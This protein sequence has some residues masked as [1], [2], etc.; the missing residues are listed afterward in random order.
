MK[1]L[2]L[3]VEG[4][5]VTL[6]AG[7]SPQ[8]IL[9]RVKRRDGS[10]GC[11]GSLGGRLETRLGSL[12]LVAARCSRA[13]VSANALDRDG[14][15]LRVETGAGAWLAVAH[16]AGFTVRLADAHGSVEEIE[17][18]A[19]REIRLSRIAAL[20]RWAMSRGLLRAPKG[21]ADY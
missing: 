17:V 2:T 20:R 21:I 19:E 8:E 5:A 12:R 4:C 14:R 6:Y 11:V 16:G 3:D 7:R 10:G 1:L 18:D 15:E 9:V 13:V